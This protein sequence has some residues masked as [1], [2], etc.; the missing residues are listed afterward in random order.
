MRDR[1]GCGVAFTVTIRIH[2]SYFSVMCPSIEEVSTAIRTLKGSELFGMDV[3]GVAMDGI[4]VGEPSVSVPPSLWS[5]LSM[6]PPKGISAGVTRFT[7][8]YIYTFLRN[9][10]T[11]RWGTKPTTF[12][13][14][15]IGYV[16]GLLNT[17][18]LNPFETVSNLVIAKNL[19][20]QEACS[21]LQAK[22]G[23]AGFYR[24]WRGTFLVS[25]NPAVQNTVFDQLKALLVGGGHG[26][27][28][29]F[30]QS[31]WLGAF[32]KAIAT[33]CTYP[34]MRAR[35]M[36][37]C[38]SDHADGPTSAIGQLSV[39]LSKEG[40]KGLYKGVKPTLVKGVTQSA[41]MVMVKEQ[42][43]NACRAAIHTMLER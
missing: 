31:F 27:G 25:L 12:W 39:V 26:K 36:V 21:I 6:F 29:G 14:L 2:P 43:D 10:Y 5:A 33:L 30:W 32:S 41:F 3:E 8:Y 17:V 16:T 22:D 11:A 13:N 37:Q 4:E 20:A 24:G 7:Y 42:I 18:V 34:A 28:L 19:S 40:P 1:Q 9:H 38:S 15:L 35:T 23:M